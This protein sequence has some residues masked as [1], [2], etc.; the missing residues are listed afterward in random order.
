VDQSVKGVGLRLRLIEP[1]DASYVFGL[2][3]DP[4][5]NIHLSPVTGSVD[6]QRAW[7]KRYKARETNGSELYYVAE[8][9]SDNQRCGVVRLYDIQD[10]RFTWGSWILDENK[11]EKAALDCAVLIYDVAFKKLNKKRSLFDVRKDNSHT[12]AFH[13]RFGAREIGADELNVY[14]ELTSEHYETVRP[15]L[16]AA[17]SK[18]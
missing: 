5:Y 13:R 1:G 14:F 10:D 16:I 7:I 11:P 6:G 15:A 12:L 9:L 17:I 8:R 4:R 2:R 18:P 3:T